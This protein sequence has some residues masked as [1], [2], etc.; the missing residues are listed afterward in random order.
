MTKLPLYPDDLRG[1]TILSFSHTEPNE[2]EVKLLD[3]R[4]ATIIPC[5]DEFE[6]TYMR[7]YE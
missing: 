2:I 5:G 1:G 4:I 7:D 3:G 6:V